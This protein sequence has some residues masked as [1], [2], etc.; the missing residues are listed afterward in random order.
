MKPGVQYVANVIIETLEI[1]NP[2]KT[3]LLHFEYLEKANYGTIVRFFDKSLSL[4]WPDRVKRENVLIFVFDAAPNM[5]KAA[6]SLKL[7]Y[8]NMERVWLTLVVEYQ[9]K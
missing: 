1:D 6:K 8:A 7:L 5:V 4:I 9:K 2:G 3:L